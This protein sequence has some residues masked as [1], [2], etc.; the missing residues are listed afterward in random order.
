MND[1]SLSTRSKGKFLTFSRHRGFTLVE[2]MMSLVLVAISAAL[3][4]PSYREMVEKRQVT[5]GAEQLASFINTAQGVA[6][7]TNSVV[8]VSWSHTNSNDWCIGAISSE[9]ACDC[10]VTNTASDSYCQI[11]AQ[12]FILSDNIAAELGLMHSMTGDGSYAFDPIR[13]VFV[14]LDDA[15][16]LELRSRSGD[17]RLN[18]MVNST[19]RVTLCSD[20]ASH[21]VPGYQL[22]E[23]EQEVESVEAGI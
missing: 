18:L 15:L 17:F 2:V 3:A 22:C 13:G 8:T 14:D 7:K 19:G 20:D 21:S 16:A 9:D 4:L 23:L 10:T 11:G 1:K 12:D 6:M 5:N